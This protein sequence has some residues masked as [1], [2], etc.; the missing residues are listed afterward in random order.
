MI[1][2]L[3]ASEILNVLNQRKEMAT[4]YGYDNFS[5]MVLWNDGFFIREACNALYFVNFLQDE[6]DLLPSSVNNH[7]TEG[8]L[9]P[10]ED[11][12]YQCFLTI[13]ELFYFIIEEDENGLYVIKDVNNH[14]DAAD[15]NENLGY[16]FLNL[17]NKNKEEEFIIEEAIN[18]L[19]SGSLNMNLIEGKELNENQ[20]IKLWQQMG[21]CIHHMTTNLET[22]PKHI[23]ELGSM[24]MEEV[25]FRVFDMEIDR[26][27]DL[28]KDI[29][30]AMVDLIWHSDEMNTEENII[31]T[32]NEINIIVGIDL[33]LDDFNPIINGRY[34]SSYFTYAFCRKKAR[35]YGEAF[36]MIVNSYRGHEELDGVIYFR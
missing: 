17:F 20:I 25:C 24:F 14:I 23:Y 10:L 33:C 3:K 34:E 28:K 2:S 18:M 4:H 19:T 22:V 32:V 30:I 5:H 31:D 16:F 21:K 11:V 6:L 35:E 15:G 13:Y 8:L 27:S 12:L 1:T 36:S 29:A 9:I 26:T 7:I